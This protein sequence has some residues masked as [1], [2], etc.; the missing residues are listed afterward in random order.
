M[1]DEQLMVMLGFMPWD[2]A[3][4]SVKVLKLEP[5]WRFACVAMLN[6]LSE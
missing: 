4:T 6:W 2:M 3:W 1:G 5:A